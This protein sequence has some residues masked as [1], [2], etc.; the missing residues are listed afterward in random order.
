[1]C[2]TAVDI[3]YGRQQLSLSTISTK[4]DELVQSLSDRVRA[5]FPNTHASTYDCEWVQY[6]TG[7]WWGGHCTGNKVNTGYRTA[8]A[9]GAMGLV[10]CCS[11]DTLHWA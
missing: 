8:F 4:V 2:N 10:R 11:I 5:M 9:P 6:T 7:N 1:M 3:I